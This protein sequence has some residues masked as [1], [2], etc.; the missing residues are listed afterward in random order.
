[1]TLYESSNEHY[2]EKE[3]WPSLDHEFKK[4]TW[5][6]LSLDILVIPNWQNDKLKFI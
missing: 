6:A 3:I 1:M 2:I 5:T 4:H